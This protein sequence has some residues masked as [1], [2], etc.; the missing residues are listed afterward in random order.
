M[1]SEHDI[2]LA[3]ACDTFHS[4]QRTSI[5]NCAAAHGIGYGTL[6]RQLGGQQSRCDANAHKQILTPQQEEERAR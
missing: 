4:G 6:S 5:R 1:P 2:S 3:Q